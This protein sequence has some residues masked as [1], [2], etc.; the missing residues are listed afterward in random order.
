MKNLLLLALT[1][2]ALVP[3]AQ[4]QTARRAAPVAAAPAFPGAALRPAA[5]PAFRLVGTRWQRAAGATGWLDSARYTFSRFTAASLPRLELREKAA[6]RGGTLAAFRQARYRYNAANALTTDSTFTYNAAGVPNA[7]ASLITAF[8]YN[9]QGRVLVEQS[10]VYVQGNQRPSSR[11]TYTYDAQG[12]NTRLLYE[13]YFGVGTNG[14]WLYDAQSTFSYNAQNQLA[15]ELF[16][17]ANI[18]GTQ[19]SPFSKITHTYNAAGAVASV[20]EQQYNNG[21]YA[22]AT[23]GTF[24]YAP[25]G[26]LSSVL[27]ER[28]GPAGTWVPSQQFTETYDIDNNLTV[29]VSQLY[30]NGAFVNDTRNLYAYQRIL[31]TRTANALAASLVALPNPATAGTPATLRYQLPAAAAVAVRVFDAT[32]RAVAAVPAAA[33]PAGPHTLALPALPTPG[34]YL[35]RLSA[36]P[37]SQTARLVV[38]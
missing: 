33:Q 3:A 14:S 10:S 13:S 9:A 28:V 32:G 29:E 35:V 11:Y 20:L 19:F 34:L 12:R 6:T 17:I 18:A 21:R 27:Y 4:A 15:Q 16:D 8:T 31:G 37:H 25:S 38:E 5:N 36:G 23:R 7:Y 2:A 26:L 22:D 24:A 30:K 1:T